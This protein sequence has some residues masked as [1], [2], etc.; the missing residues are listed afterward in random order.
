MKLSA[1][2]ITMN[3]AS[4]VR[5][6]LDSIAWA[7]EIVVVDSGSTDNTLDIC[8][9]YTTKIL[10][11][12]WPGPGA[13]RNRAIDMA[14]GEWILALD[15]D[16]WISPHLRAEIQGVISAPGDKVAYEMPRLSSYCGKYIRHSGWWPDRIMR[17]FKRNSARFNAELVHDHLIVEGN[18][19]RLSNHLMHTAFENLEEVLKKL[20]RYSTDGAKVK[21]KKGKKANLCTAIFHGL[22]SFIHTYIIRGGFLD[23]RVGFVLAVS[24]AE[25]TYYKYLKLMFMQKSSI[26]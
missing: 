8:S 25:G 17:L 22:W 10:K 26:S 6:C 18:V 14:E 15:A 4:V 9:E 2:L 23:G 1:I 20:N 5:R 11:T 13:Q 12:D 24:N 3:E 19:G 16:E 21:F 7:D